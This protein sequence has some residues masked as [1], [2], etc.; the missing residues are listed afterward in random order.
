MTKNK[1][2]SSVQLF[3]GVL[4]LGLANAASAIQIETDDAKI[5][6]YGYARLNASYDINEDISRSSGTRSGDFSQVNTGAAENSEASGYFGADA[7]QSRLGIRTRMANGVMVN[8]EGDFR[9]GANG[10]QLRLRHAYGQ[11]GNW[12]MGRTWSNYNSFVGNTSVLEMDGVAGNAGLY[13]RTAQVRYIRGNFAFAVEDPKPNILGQATKSGL[14]TLTAR[15]ENK[16]GA[17]KFSSAALLQEVGYDTGTN[18]DS[19]FGYAVFGAAKFQVTDTLSI[20]GNVNYTDG[21]NS[22]LWRSGT[23]YYGEDAYLDGNNV[24]TIT[25]YSANLGTTIKVGPGSLS[26]VYGMTTMDW[27]D[28]TDD[29]LSVGSKHERNTN[30][31]LTYK[32]SPVKS[33]MLGVEYGR[34][35]VKKVSGDEGDG[36][37]LMFAAQYNF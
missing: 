10:G 24:E 17:L 13:N 8:V 11:Y 27:D 6:I 18:D 30:A 15:Y 31:F 26:A 3:S 37:R 4:I 33:V 16:A 25:G 28:A 23:N 9:G 19:V 12:L 2:S 22:Y 36:N 14:P 21:A 5:D 29:G 32:W 1:L 7:V 35:E 20:Q 34:Y